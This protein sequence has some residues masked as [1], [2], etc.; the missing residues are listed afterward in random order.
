MYKRNPA[1][2]QAGAP[3][4]EAAGTEVSRSPKLPVICQP[5]HFLRKVP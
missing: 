5:K 3:F 1:K 4:N 2:E